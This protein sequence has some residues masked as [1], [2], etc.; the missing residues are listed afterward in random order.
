MFEAVELGRN[1]SREDYENQLPALRADLIEAQQRIRQTGFPVLII[2]AG[3]DGAD[4]GE[5]VHRLNEWLD[6]RGIDTYSFWNPS[7]EESERPYYW[8]FWRTLP[9]RGRIGIYYGAWYHDLLLARTRR[10]IHADHLE[11]ELAR[12]AA[13]ERMLVEDGMLIVKFWF[14]LSRKDQRRRLKDR[15][16]SPDKRLAM[17]DQNRKHGRL[18]A[19]FAG[20]SEAMIRHTDTGFAPWRLIE[21][22]QDRY[23]DL[24]AG[25]LLLEAL[26]NRLAQ[27]QQKTPRRAP[28]PGTARRPQATVLDKVDLSL[29]LGKKAYAKELPKLQ[30]ELNRLTWKAYK[31]Q[32]SSLLVF[33]GWDAAG[34]GSAIR[35]V[36]EAVDA[37]LFRVVPVAAPTEEERAHHYLWRFWRQ[38]PRGGLVTIFDRSWYGRVLVE[39]VEGFASPPEW[40]RAFHEINEFERQLA[41]HGIIV[42]KFWLH[43]SR[44]EQMER[45]RKREH[46]PHKN[47]KITAEDWRNR[48]R[49]PQYELAVHDMVVHTGTP[50]APWSLVSGN[51][52]QVA[53]LE[54]LRVFIRALQEKL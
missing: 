9:A 21:A 41:E 23:R 48:K 11:S 17:L 29:S 28:R 49:W 13:F 20:A 33:E 35:R 47:Y 26:Q 1:V 34:K 15:P 16:K 38:L 6:P 2:I 27:A 8:R 42:L 7:G 32:M 24:T 3:M 39:R 19:R 31:R 53:R 44:Q 46:V 30:A 25:Q 52:K 51:D 36:T 40:M 43:I 18:Y 10:K 5:V 12:I 22:A 50:Y 14:H 4:K 45:F 37:R 54:I